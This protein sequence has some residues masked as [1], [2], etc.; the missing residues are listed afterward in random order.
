MSR[1]L[2]ITD[3]PDAQLIESLPRLKAA[4]EEQ[5]RFRIEQLA[6]L[7][8]QGERLRG[9]PADRPLDA[10]DASADTARDEVTAALAAAAR[11][12][13]EDIEA[14][15]DRIRADRYGRCLGCGAEIPLE[16]L[17]AI[18]QTGACVGCQRRLERRRHM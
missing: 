13:L 11:H 6:D 12:A 14:A 9:G 15:L 5:R 16:R 8:T 7:A 18:P 1:T 17:R 3:R 2:T 10:L 4:L